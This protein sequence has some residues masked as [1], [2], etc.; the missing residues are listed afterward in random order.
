MSMRI[1]ER[2]RLYFEPV[3]PVAPSHTLCE[4]AAERECAWLPLLDDVAVLVE[5]QPGILEELCTA[6]AKIDPAG[7]GRRDCSTVQAD[8]EGVLED[9]YVMH[10]PLEEHFERST[11]PSGRGIARSSH[12][13][14]AV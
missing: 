13:T 8:E 10:G 9:L 12:L 3:I 7:P 6:A 11:D 2:A 4:V 5:H 1:G 14:G